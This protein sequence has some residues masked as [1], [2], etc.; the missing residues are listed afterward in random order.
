MFTLLSP[1]LDI[2]F[3]VMSYIPFISGFGKL[4]RSSGLFGKASGLYFNKKHLL[5]IKAYEKAINYSQGMEDIHPIDMAFEQAYL[6]LAEM[7]EKGLGT[8][9]N[10]MQA[11]EFYLKAGTR[12]NIAYEH[13]VATKSCYDNQ[14][15]K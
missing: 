4:M 12:G 14:S 13:K 7:H 1:M 6:A 11:E 15:N 10:Q 9:K 3:F 2:T 8:E 5:S